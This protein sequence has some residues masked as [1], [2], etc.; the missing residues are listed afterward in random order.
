MATAYNPAANY[1]IE[2]W[3]VEFRRTPTR[4]LM[5]H[6]WVADPAPQTDRAHEMIR[7]FIGKQLR[8]LQKA[9]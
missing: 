5:A 3:D 2:V 9:A 4:Q 6:M 7:A 1:D 8:A